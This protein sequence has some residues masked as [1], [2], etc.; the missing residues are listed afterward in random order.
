M[1][2]L[3]ILFSLA[4]L[5]A[6][7]AM[8]QTKLDFFEGLSNPDMIQWMKDR[9]S[10]WNKQNPNYEVVVTTK[11]SYRA[12][13][14]SAILAARQGNP[15][16]MVQIFEV[17]SQQAKDSGIFVPVGSIPGAFDTSDYIKPVLDYYTIGGTVN[18]IPFNSSNAVMYVNHALMT[19]A[20]LNPDNPP[21]TFSDVVKDCDALRAAG[22]SADACMTFP[23][24]SWFFEQWMAEQNAPLVNNDNGRGGRA[25]KVLLTSQPALNIVNWIKELHDKGYYTYTGK[26][27]NW[28]GSEAI[29]TQGKAMFHLDSTSEVGLITKAGKDGGWTATTAELPIPDGAPRQGVVIG[30]ASIWISKGIPQAQ[31]VA[32]R[33]FL[34]YMTNT[35]NM[36]SWH[37]LTGYFPVRISSVNAL[38]KAGWFRENPNYAVAFTQL[39]NTKASTATAG[40]L[41]GP[42]PQVRTIIEQAIQKVIN[43]A[44][45]DSAMSQA[46]A[47]ADQAL[48]QYNSNFQ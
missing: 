32:A 36:I 41:M 27:E 38:D 35:Q 21:K 45:V 13:L 7:T 15:P 12:A 22:D 6:G 34:E 24:H 40:A 2:R 3:T 42:F 16:A 28:N 20:G 4:L 11:P 46:Q 33:S 25:T 5:L 29:F 14:S 31:Q 23:L 30:G 8:A 48:Q 26:L 19:K 39:L 9:A 10:E 47:L 43:G 37:K 1:K 18:S 44:T 17:G